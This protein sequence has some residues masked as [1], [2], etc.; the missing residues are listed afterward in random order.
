MARRRL[1]ALDPYKPLLA[2]ELARLDRRRLK[3]GV[4]VVALADR[5]GIARST[6]TRIRA[7]GR[8]WPRQV[9]ALKMALRSIER[10]AKAEGAL[11]P[12]DEDADAGEGGK[13]GPDGVFGGG[14]A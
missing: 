12:G 10:E 8:A 3:A 1:K 4:S 9:R 7:S 2:D 11:F 14:R 5:A 6:M 13:A